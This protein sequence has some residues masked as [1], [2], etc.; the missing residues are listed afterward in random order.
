MGLIS[1][2]YIVYLSAEVFGRGS[3]PKSIQ[4]YLKV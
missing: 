4:T 1:F 2:K 3:H